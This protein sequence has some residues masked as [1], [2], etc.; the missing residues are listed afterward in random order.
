M[1]S[2][3]DDEFLTIRDQNGS[4]RGRT[5]NGDI[6]LPIANW[7]VSVVA[8]SRFLPFLRLHF[9]G[10]DSPNGEP[11]SLGYNLSV[12]GPMV[13]VA[14][15]S[16]HRIDPAAGEDPAYLSLVTKT[17]LR[18]T[19][20]RDGGLVIVFTDDDR[21]EVPQFQYEPWQLAGDDGSLVVSVAGGGLALWDPDPTKLGRT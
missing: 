4:R 19:A 11:N 2:K 21:L 14:N 17:V 15:S 7:A 9:Y 18:A 16:E 5:S 13:I 12:E 20:S 6:D 1:T 10:H 3:P 8:V